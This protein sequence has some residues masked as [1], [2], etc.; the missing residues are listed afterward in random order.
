MLTKVAVLGV[1]RVGTAVARAALEAGMSVNVA[2]SGAAEDIALIAEII[3]PGAVALTAADAV[4]DADLVVVAVPLNKFRTLDPTMLDG[5]IVIDVM[6]HWAE[7][8]GSLDEISEDPRGTSEIVAEHLAGARLVKTLNHIGYHEIEDDARRDSAEG[9]RALAIAG[10]DADAVNAAAEFVDRLGF[11][12]V[13]A[14]A[15]PVGVAFEAGTR[16]FFGSFDAVGMR[17]ALADAGV[18]LPASASVGIR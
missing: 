18:A 12:P 1:G 16:I 8:D 6:N 14:G 11:E 15:L 4:A 2:A 7:V 17:D 3:T 9:R 10:D 13:V 5:K